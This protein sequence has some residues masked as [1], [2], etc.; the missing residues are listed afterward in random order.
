MKSSTVFGMW[1]PLALV[2][3]VGTMLAVARQN[4]IGRLRAENESLLSQKQ[5]AGRLAKENEGIGRLRAQV[6]GMEKIRE[7]NKDLPRLRNEVRQM[8]RGADEL[9]K[10]R[11]ENQR[12][13]EQ[14]K[15]SAVPAAPAGLPDGFIPKAA[16]V[17]AGL[18][19]PEATVQTFFS[20][21]CRG[22]VH[23]MSQCTVADPGTEPRG[24]DAER[25]RQ[26]MMNELSAFPGFAI[27][28]KKTISPSEVELELKTQTDGAALPMK[29]KLVGAEWKMEN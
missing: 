22:D 4:A 1:F 12:L 27:A 17:D 26:D 10:L 29:L 20:A 9:A 15:N 2:V 25:M 11:A 5:E 6:E 14:A 16:L 13:L 23:R 19:S 18:G 24:A 7:E 8:R 3:A 28:G 21:A